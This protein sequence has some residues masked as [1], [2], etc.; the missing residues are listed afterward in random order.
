MSKFK[1]Q[2]QL[3]TK[4]RV[5]ESN[6]IKSYFRIKNVRGNIKALH[7][8]HT[9]HKR[10]TCTLAFLFIIFFFFVFASESEVKFLA[11]LPDFLQNIYVDPARSVVSF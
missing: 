5:S 6:K 11:I 4:K 10:R 3:Q 8:R 2:L 1:L 7:R 9:T